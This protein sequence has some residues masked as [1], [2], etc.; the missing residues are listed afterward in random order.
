MTAILVDGYP[1]ADL[2]NCLALRQAARHVTQFYDQFLVP[3]GLRISQFGILAKLRRI[4]PMTI[5]ALARDLVLDRTTLGR[6]ILPLEREGLI[7]IKKSRTDRRSKELH[8]TERGRE[9]LR[10]A[11]EGW[12]KAQEQFEAKFGDARSAELR[13]MLRSITA[14]D[15]G[16]DGDAEVEI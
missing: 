13:G 11:V 9:R 4:G 16:V 3:T 1:K 8:L 10:A 5:N 7:E 12:V 6:N 14:Q 15:L 2:C